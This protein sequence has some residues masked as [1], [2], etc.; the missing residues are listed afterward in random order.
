M[1][2]PFEM[3]PA[4]LRGEIWLALTGTTVLLLAILGFLYG[5]LKNAVASQGMVS[6]ELSGTPE[7][8]NQILASWNEKIRMRVA[9]TLGLNFLCLCALTNTLALSCVLA[10]GAIGDRIAAA[11]NLLAWGQ[12]V[13]AGCWA[14][15]NTIL[16]CGVLGHAT[17][18][19]LSLASSLAILKFTL[20]GA[21]L[22]FAVLAGIGAAV[23]LP[24]R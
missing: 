12:W 19:G 21:G 22:L 8:L 4:A 9:F 18:S 20:V 15:Q 23:S 13:A 6:L 3:I 14:V 1:R 10:G 5:P 24:A 17:K 7:R 11:G 2:H 16:V